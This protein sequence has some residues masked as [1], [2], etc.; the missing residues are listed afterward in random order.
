MSNERMSVTTRPEHPL[1]EGELE[2]KVRREQ[3]TSLY[4]QLPTSIT[5]TLIGMLV[6]AFAMWDGSP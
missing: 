4:L 1:S 6:L 5:G 2:T 3:V